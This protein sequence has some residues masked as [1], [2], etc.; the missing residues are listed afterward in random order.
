MSSHR[1]PLNDT[2]V[3][4][5]VKKGD[6]KEL[7]SQQAKCQQRI[8]LRMVKE[9]V[10]RTQERG[11]EQAKRIRDH[12]I[13]EHASKV[14]TQRIK[15]RKANELK[16]LDDS[17]EV[18]ILNQT[19]SIEAMNVARMLSPRFGQHFTFNSALDLKEEFRV[20]NLLENDRIGAFYR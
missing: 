5:S 7:V 6:N 18:L 2:R 19:S 15:E 4:L 12:Q 1:L 9:M 11:D 13:G 3:S 17:V 14:A 16:K 20:K 10:L 8:K